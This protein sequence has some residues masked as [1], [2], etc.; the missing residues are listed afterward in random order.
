MNREMMEDNNLLRHKKTK[1]KY[2]RLLK[3]CQK[4]KKTE[5]NR[6]CT[7]DDYMEFSGAMVVDKPGV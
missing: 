3:K 4:H 7:L 5:K 2:T 6:K 1:T